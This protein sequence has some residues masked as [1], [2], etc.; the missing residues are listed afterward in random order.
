MAD[1]NAKF[2]GSY[3]NSANSYINIDA[4]LAD[5]YN[6]GPN[7]YMPLLIDPNVP[8][9]LANI[10]AHMQKRMDT[11]KSRVNL[12]ELYFAGITDEEIIANEKSKAP[13]IIVMSSGR[14]DWIKIALQNGQNAIDALGGKYT[15]IVTDELIFINGP[16]PFYFPKRY[17][18][19]SAKRNFYIFVHQTEYEWYANELAGFGI[20]VI[21]WNTQRDNLQADKDYDVC[22][23]FGMSRYAVFQFFKDFFKLPG[24]PSHKKIWMLDDN[25]CHIKGFPGFSTCENRNQNAGVG[26][27][28]ANNLC[29]QQFFTT[30]GSKAQGKSIEDEFTN[31]AVDKP[32]FIQQGMLWNF[33]QIAD[34]LSFSPYFI[35]SNEDITFGRMLKK[36][37]PSNS[38]TI[39]GTTILKCQTPAAPSDAVI[40]PGFVIH[41]NQKD[42]I[43]LC[44]SDPSNKNNL[45]VL[46]TKTKVAKELFEF[47]GDID[48][49]VR[50]KE[51]Q[52]LSFVKSGEQIVRTGMHQTGADIFDAV[53]EGCFITSGTFYIYRYASTIAPSNS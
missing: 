38:Y 44:L 43:Y 4:D 5:K 15:G 49:D 29:A 23:G 45:Q 52:S 37:N 47:M 48:I 12:N 41:K 39:S 22:L 42:V 6:K 17:T 51:T 2:N 10:K 7:K 20:T 31:L 18:G 53:P 32:T 26:F 8:M 28:V 35:A 33:A 36:Y 46:N 25:L 3:L 19:E 27:W 16:V 21:G 40:D 1:L 14:A 13:P 50:S 30:M 9:N 24:S 11:F 34:E